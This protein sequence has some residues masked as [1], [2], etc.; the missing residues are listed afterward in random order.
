[1]RGYQ[2][3]KVAKSRKVNYGQDAVRELFTKKQH[4]MLELSNYKEISLKP[5]K[6]PDKAKIPVK[7]YHLLKYFY[8]K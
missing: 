5:T 7:N 4:L 8:L 1:V 3:S 2:A 6:S